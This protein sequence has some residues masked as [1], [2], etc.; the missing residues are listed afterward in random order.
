MVSDLYTCHHGQ[1]KNGSADYNYETYIEKLKQA[2][3]D[4]Y[5]YGKWHAGKGAPADFGAEGIFCEDYG[6]PYLL[7]EYKKYLKEKGLPF[8]RAYI[9]NDWCTP[10]WIDDMT[11]GE[12]KVMDHPTMNECVSGILT[13]PKETHEVFYLA[14][15]ACKK[16]QELKN[17]DRPFCLQVEFWGHISRI[18]R[19]RSMQICTHRKRFRNIRVSGM[20][21]V[22]N[23][24]YIILK[25]E[26][27]SVRIT[28]LF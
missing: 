1:I 7:P 17:S 11:E 24:I 22:I 8:P 23:R 26:K 18:C 19:H 2:G 13:T 5:Y 12:E 10:G 27:E 9:E 4:V 28:E 20:I 21:S 3:Y 14:Y 15:E 16:L 6:N 25:V